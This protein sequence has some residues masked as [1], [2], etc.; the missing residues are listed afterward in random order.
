MIRSLFVLL[1]LAVQGAQASWSIGEPLKAFSGLTVKLDY[2]VGAARKADEVEILFYT[3]GECKVPFDWF[4]VDKPY[5]TAD[6]YKG[7]GDGDGG[8]IVSSRIRMILQIVCCVF[9]SHFDH[10]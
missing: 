1:A 4:N 7:L 6:V 3:D 8:G 2:P 9:Q 5:L 10:R